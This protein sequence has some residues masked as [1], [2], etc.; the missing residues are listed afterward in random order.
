MRTSTASAGKNVL[1]IFPSCN[2]KIFGNNEGIGA[3]KEKTIAPPLGILYLSAKLLDAGYHVE[4]CDYNA[5]DYSADSVRQYIAGA[6][7]VGIS[8]LSFNRAN[9]MEI[10]AEIN[11]MRPELPVIVGGPDCILHPRLISGTKATAVEESESIIVPLVEAVLSG[12]DL[13]EVPGILYPHPLTGE[14]VA[15]AAYAYAKEL[16]AI[17]FPRRELLRDNKGY[18]IIGEKASR[19]VTSIIT[20]RGC[21][22]RCRFCAH[23]AIAYQKYRARSA[24]NVLAE[25]QQLAKDGFEIVGIVDDNFTA[26]KKRATEIL[27]GI[28]DLK[29]KFSMAVQGRV[30]AADYELFH[31][32]RKAGVKVVT[33]GLE[34]GNQD[35]LDFYNKQSTVAMNEKAIRLADKAGL[36]TGGLFIIGAPF[37]TKEH[38][39]R[40]Y[41]F[42][43]DLPLDI[44]SFWVLDYT[45]G[46]KLWEEAFAAGKVKREEFNV[47][48][49]L[50]RGTSAYPTEE[51]QRMSEKYFYRFYRRPAYWLRQVLKLLRVRDYYFMRVMMVGIFW[52]VQRKAQ[53]LWARIAGRRPA[54]R[55]TAPTPTPA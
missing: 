1:F 32:M 46:S 14:P 28:I 11:R 13:S 12:G 51:L 2:V 6:D 29:L 37:E 44:S 33:F 23:N 42:A 47:P 25:L 35:V 38:F 43:A 40:T 19:N 24:A 41:R 18:N 48:A 17:K 7:I 21:P 52:L 30:D 22:K 8:M 20:S 54:P 4:A 36:Y 49:G 27:Y 34:S 5:E 3:Q 10:I 55:P 45:Y 26:D 15:G 31:L 50:E 39:D 16:D 9:A 53:I